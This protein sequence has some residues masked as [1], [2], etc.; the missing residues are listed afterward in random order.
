MRLFTSLKLV[1]CANP[2]KSNFLVV[3]NYQAKQIIPMLNKIQKAIVTLWVLMSMLPLWAANDDTK[4]NGIRSD[5]KHSISVG[6]TTSEEETGCETTGHESE[7]YS[8]ADRGGSV[9]A[10]L[11]WD[12]N[13][14]VEEYIVQYTQNGGHTTLP[15]TTDTTVFIENLLAETPL[16][17]RVRTKCNGVWTSFPGWQETF[18]TSSGSS[19]ETTGH[20]SESYSDAGR[21]GSIVAN[22]RWDRNDF[23][24]EYIVQY[25]QNGGH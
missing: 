8:D 24:E 6:L 4:S 19:C 16:Q 20:E 10:N 22:L 12:R 9:V 17:W 3:G 15:A 7:S 1:G 14:F 13:D 25:T 23:V 21:G 2:I 11:R 18:T 5:W